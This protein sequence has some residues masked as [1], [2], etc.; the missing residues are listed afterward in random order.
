M[1]VRDLFGRLYGPDLVNTAKT[2]PVYYERIFDDAQV[3]PGQAIEGLYAAAAVC[4]TSS[5]AVLCASA[6]CSADG[7]PSTR[8]AW[9]RRSLLTVIDLVPD[10]TVD[11]EVSLS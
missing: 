10:S 5:T 3:E 11:K 8:R 7:R 4:T 1:E 2:G 9:R 6:W